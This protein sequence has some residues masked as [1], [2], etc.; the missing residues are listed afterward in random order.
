MT[1]KALLLG[2]V[3]SASPQ[4]SC[5]CGG[6]ERH[7]RATVTVPCSECKKEMPYRSDKLCETCAVAADRCT[8]C[9]LGLK[10]MAAWIGAMHLVDKQPRAD[11]TYYVLVRESGG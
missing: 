3:L 9:G 4:D 1:I 2:L 10:D 5:A 6:C 7:S 11:L 8:H